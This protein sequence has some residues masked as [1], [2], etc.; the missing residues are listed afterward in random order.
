MEIIEYITKITMSANR[1]GTI[2]ECVKNKQRS[3]QLLKL[4]YSQDSGYETDLSTSLLE[5]SISDS[6]V[7]L[8]DLPTDRKGDCTGNDNE[9]DYVLDTSLD[10][11]SESETDREVAELLGHSLKIRNTHQIHEQRPS[12]PLPEAALCR[13]GME[14]KTKCKRIKA[15]KPGFDIL[16]N[17]MCRHDKTLTVCKLCSSYYFRPVERIDTATGRGSYIA[18][19]SAFAASSDANQS[20]LSRVT[21]GKL[22]HLLYTMM[23]LIMIEILMYAP[24]FITQSYLRSSLG[25]EK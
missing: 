10:C 20:A 17:K 21:N 11:D 3:C 12:A 22:V 14:N 25:N 15:E 16:T 4:D 18:G 7:R 1:K 13:D 23:L 6:D 24:D 5:T 19:S 8:K 2:T 9:G